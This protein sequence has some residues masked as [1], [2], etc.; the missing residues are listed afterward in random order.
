MGVSAASEITQFAEG[1]P[2]KI[3]REVRKVKIC[4]TLAAEASKNLESME[5]PFEQP[6]R[7]SLLPHQNRVSGSILI[8][9]GFNPRS[10]EHT[11]KNI[12]KHSFFLAP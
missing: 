4:I 2:K 12:V 7:G 11:K 8:A 10:K 1:E 5:S 3:S 6:V 9:V